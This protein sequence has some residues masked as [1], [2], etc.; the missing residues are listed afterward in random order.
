M[1]DFES[2]FPKEPQR[3]IVVLKHCEHQFRHARLLCQGQLGLHEEC[4]EAAF[5][6]VT[7]QL[8]LIAIQHR[9][10]VV[11]LEAEMDERFDAS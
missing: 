6:H 3:H 11:G 9:V 7:S 5:A 4:A 10:T 8:D 1:I 2:E